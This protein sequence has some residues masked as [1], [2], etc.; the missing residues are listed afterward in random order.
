MKFCKDC[1]FFTE[2]LAQGEC[3]SPNVSVTIDPVFG[4]EI[5]GYN[6]VAYCSTMRISDCGPDA[7]WFEPKE[8]A[9]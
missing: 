5:R 9:P 3:Q 1:R 4:R 8:A 6:G 7:K 2:V